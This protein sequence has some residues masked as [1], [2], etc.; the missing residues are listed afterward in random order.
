MW[1]DIKSLI[2]SIATVLFGWIGFSVKTDLSTLAIVVSI[3]AGLSTIIYNAINIYIKLKKHK[4][5]GKDK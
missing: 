4:N 1:I 2:G 3:L 5:V